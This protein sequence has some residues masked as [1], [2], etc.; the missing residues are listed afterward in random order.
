M[1]A[2]AADRLTSSLT[3][4]S[5]FSEGAGVSSPSRL[6]QTAAALGYQYLGLADELS[7]GGAVELHQQAQAHG[8]KAVIGATV[9]F[10]TES[11]RY[12]L[13]LI[14]ASRQGYR[15]LNELIT[16]ARSREAQAVPLSALEPRSD[17][18][19]ALTG[20]RDGFPSQLLGKRRAREAVSLVAR[21]QAIFHDRLLVQL[22][23][24][25]EP[26]DAR[27]V[28]ALR[29]LARE[30]GLRVVAAP[31]VRYATPDLY[32]LYDALVCGRLGITVRQPHQQRPR[33][34]S[35]HLPSPEEG[36]ERLPYPD[37]IANAQAIARE[38]Q[39]E[40]LAERLHPAPARVP[41]GLTAYQFLEERCYAALGE[42]YGGQDSYAQARARLDEELGTI[43]AFAVADVFLLAA[44]VTDYCKARG[45]IAAGRGSAA[46]SVV[47]YLLGVSLVDPIQHQ[48]LFERFLHLGKASMPDIDLDVSS[49]RRDEVLDWLEA[50]FPEDCEG[51]VA[52]RITYRLPSALQD[53]GRALGIPQELRNRLTR[54]LGRDY[55]GLSPRRAREAIVVFDEVLGGSPAQEVLLGLLEKME[56]G[57][58]RHHAP[59]S[60][61]VIATKEPLTAYT[62]L[63]V[64]SGGIKLI[65]YDKDDA[66][67]LGLG[68]LDI[69]GL[70]MLSVF[71]S[72]LREIDR[73]EGSQPDLGQ[74]PD[75][76]AIWQRISQGDTLG[77]FQ[78]ESPAQMRISVELQP[79]CLEDLAPQVAIIRPGPIQAHTV[80]PYI[81][82][83]QGREPITYA[84]PALEPILG[85]SLGV[86]LYQEDVLRVAVHFAGMS[87][88][89]GE[90][91]RKKV[92][93]S[94]EPI[95]LEPDRQRFLAGAKRHVGASEEQATS[96]FEMIQAYQGFGFAE[97]HARAFAGHAY[98]SAWLRHHYPAE[99][100]AGVLSHHPGMWPLE[101][102]RQEARNW[103]VPFLK[104]DLNRSGRHYHVERHDG[105]KAIRPPLCAIKG[106]SEKSAQEIL[107]S[108]LTGGPFRSID[109][110][111]G[112]VKLERDELRALVLAGAFDGLHE[113]REALYRLKALSHS[114]PA[115]NQPL[116]TAV[117]DVPAL[118]RLTTR[119]A[120]LWDTQHKG[121]SEREMHL[122]DL[123]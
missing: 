79:S 103:N 18:L 107:L 62:P 94:S 110:L 44:E 4:H 47:C 81:R 99:Y 22:Y 32:P 91:F 71:E 83:R 87:W 35:Q 76:P 113:R 98:T 115:G 9:P 7:V 52:N 63:S 53:L 25:Q 11:E 8:I 45:I 21:L 19:F 117:P 69:L 90:R 15:H 46:A 49:A 16:L 20:T 95:D 108:R 54:S 58:F 111:Y 78:L 72:C 65:Q 80:H 42:R 59:H 67:A 104:L 43:K 112:R 122:L 23:H 105:I 109:E 75:E 120:F 57:H 3:V 33:N 26:W 30:H 56:A 40:L 100:L 93:G 70:L 74:L 27:R 89:E 13:V 31:E 114:Q 64:S 60:G 82:R 68:K 97:S 28:R 12:P 41:E 38:A 85:K 84:H 50:R 17:G 6:V 123:L 102:I 101:S 24:N 14:A 73:L 118:D 2:R 55:R 92:T 66:E 48:L 119:E 39:F 29:A 51:M 88:L 61:G 77:L 96:V 1:G 37:A 116:F 36:W 5:Y 34:E 10:T 106:V 121:Y 86:L